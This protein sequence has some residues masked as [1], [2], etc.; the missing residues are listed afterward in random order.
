MTAAP[1]EP[2]WLR[3]TLLGGATFDWMLGGFSVLLPDLVLAVLW[4]DAGAAA[5][6]LLRRTGVIWLVFAIAQTAAWRRPTPERL[7]AVVLLRLMDVPADLTWWGSAT[8]LSA[9]GAWTI[10]GA[11]L[12]N[13]TLSWL[14][15]KAS[16]TVRT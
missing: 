14:F 16:K 10:G 8:G 9:F 11:P 1:H 4:P 13:L 6:A 15:W 7:R 5:A 3:T 12:A 2:A